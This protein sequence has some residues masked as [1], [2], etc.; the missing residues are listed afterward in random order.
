MKYKKDDLVKII[1]T[2]K[3][4]SEVLKKLNLNPKGGGK[5][6][7]TIV[8]EILIENEVY[9]GHA[10]NKGK[11]YTKIKDEDFFIKGD[12]KRN[13]WNIRQ[14]LFKRG[15]KEKKCENFLSEF[16]N[17]EVLHFVGH[18]N[19]SFIDSNGQQHQNQIIHSNSNKYNFAEKFDLNKKVKSPLIILNN[20]FSGVRVSY[21]YVYDKGIYLQLMN[22]NA[23]NIVVSG[24]KIDD[25]VSSR[26]MYHF[27][28][29]L[30]QGNFVGESLVYAKRK[31]LKENKNGYANP[32]YWSP[33]F[34]IS[35]QKVRFRR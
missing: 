13:Y 3:T 4:I 1:G 8:R 27:Y 16:K 5:Y 11:S 29:Y 32:K 21:S 2:S 24:D 9:N 35:S 34:S 14:A 28:T 6:L 12:K 31:F 19:D 7:R 18:G 25:Y 22:M 26:I 23:K 20:C 17:D 33:F 15:I 10:H 30:S